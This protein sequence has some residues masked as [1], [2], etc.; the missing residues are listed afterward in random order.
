MKVDGKIG[1]NEIG[2][3]RNRTRSCRTALKLLL[4]AALF[5]QNCSPVYPDSKQLI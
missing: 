3:A 1:L 5:I 2:M 4:K